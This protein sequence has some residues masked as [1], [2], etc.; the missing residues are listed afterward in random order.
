MGEGKPIE[1]ERRLSERR[2]HRLRI[3]R[4][5][6]LFNDVALRTRRALM[7]FNDV[8]SRTRRALSP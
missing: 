6:M 5:L 1:E 2:Y 4:A 3:G 7:L 8:P